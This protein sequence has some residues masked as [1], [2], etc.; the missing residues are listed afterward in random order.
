MST[1]AIDPPV[2][3]S[4]GGSDSGGSA[5]IQADLKTC[6]ARG[7]FGCTAITVV[8]AQNTVSVTGAHPL[9]EEFIQA[10]IDAVMSDIAPQTLKTGLLGRASVVEMVARINVSNRVIDPVLLD[11]SGRQIVSDETVTAYREK[12]FPLA[13][14]ITPNLDEAALL[15]GLSISDDP[16]EMARKLHDFGPDF[17][18]IKGGH[19]TQTDHIIDLL[20]DGENYIEL[21]APRL[22]VENPHG[23]GCTFASAIA[24]ELAKGQRP[25]DAVKIAH[26]YLH[27]A[28]KGSLDWKLGAGRSPVNHGVGRVSL[29]ED[30]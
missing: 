21:T 1:N 24:A 12:L 9:P 27:A 8:T 6:E 4:I 5:G 10:Q 7:V 25:K 16:R 20:Y 19:L 11:G 28:L 18:L 30:K 13:T 15:A 3:L 2:V 23:V 22:P 26:E 14:V 17:V 29:F